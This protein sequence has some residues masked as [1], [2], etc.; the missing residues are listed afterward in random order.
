MPELADLLRLRKSQIRPVAEVLARAFQNDPIPTYFY[1][2]PA[3]RVNKAPYM[4]AFLTGYGIRY[5]EAYATSAS[6]EG[7][8]VWLPSDKVN[9]TLWRIIFSGSL[10][11]MF[12]FGREAG[13]RMRRFGEY[14]DSVHKRLVPGR[15]WYLQ[16]IG[17][18]PELQGRKYSS[19]LVR[20]M[21][22]RTDREGVPCYLET[23]TEKNVGIYERFGFKVVE[24]F[25]VPDIDFTNWAM[26]RQPSP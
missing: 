15:H 5:G 10:T 20:C 2:D 1:P 6:F 26:L 24:Q 23:Q 9:I 4:Y 16:I 8:A 25:K 21:L 11:T 22:S 17:V 14:M 18:E 19:K 3:E 7:A 12:K 13:N